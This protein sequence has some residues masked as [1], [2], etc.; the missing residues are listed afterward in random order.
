MQLCRLGCGIWKGFFMKKIMALVLAATM[1]LS[2]AACGSKGGKSAKSDDAVAAIK[3]AGKITMVTNAEFRPFEYKDGNKVIGIDADLA[4]AVADDLGVKLEITDIAFDSCIPALKAGK[5]DFCM[6][7]MSVTEDRKKNADF[8]NTY[9][10]ASQVILVKKGNTDISK[11]K[12]LDG[13]VVGV[14]QGTTGDTYCTNEDG[15]NDI[16]VKEV[17]RYQKFVDAVSDLIAGRI[18]AVV[19]DDYPAKQFLKD[20]EGKI[21]KVSDNL[22]TEEYAAAVPKGSNLA[23][24]I[25]KVIKKL[26]D[27]GEMNQIIDKYTSDSAQ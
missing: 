7:G 25:N 13:K 4:Q 6:A 8:T 12:D 20:N 16:S 14:Q 19:L 15:K 9:F 3:K 26:S 22:T 18:D 11:P 5:A 1:A 10:N 2:M 17:K 21:E 23:G 24:E 27:S